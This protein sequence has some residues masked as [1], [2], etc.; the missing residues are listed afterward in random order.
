MRTPKTFRAA[1]LGILP[2]AATIHAA[3]TYG[4]HSNSGCKPI[5]GDVSWPSLEEWDSLNRTVGGRLV[6]T[7]LLG[8]ICHKSA[9]STISG[10]VA[11]GKYN[12]SA[13]DSLQTIYDNLETQFVILPMISPRRFHDRLTNS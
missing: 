12:E 2:L 4:N 10:T 13:C 8:S 6:A 5:P 3:P 1:L 7:E 9:E 11:M